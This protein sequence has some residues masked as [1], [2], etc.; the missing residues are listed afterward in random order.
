VDTVY[1]LIQRAR[2]IYCQYNMQ[3]RCPHPPIK[4]RVRAEIRGNPGDSKRIYIII[5]RVVAAGV[6][7]GNIYIYVR[8]CVCVCLYTTYA[9]R[10]PLKKGPSPPGRRCRWQ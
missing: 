2:K 7:I 8:V 5:I 1:D 3:S 4:P 10:G 9:R 6:V